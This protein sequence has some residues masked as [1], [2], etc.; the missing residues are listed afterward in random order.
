MTASLIE[1]DTGD[2]VH[3]K[4]STEDVE[5]AGRNLRQLFFALQDFVV[6]SLCVMPERYQLVAA[7]ESGVVSS[8]QI[9]PADE[10]R[11]AIRK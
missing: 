3:L 1:R 8:I 5:I 10:Q 7:V 11:T 6:T 4:F 2:V 9:S